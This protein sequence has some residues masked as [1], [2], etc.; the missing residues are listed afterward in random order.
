MSGKYNFQEGD[1]VALLNDNLEGKVVR[2]LPGNKI[3]VQTADGFEMPLNPAEL[4]LVKSHSTETRTGAPAAE[5]AD[6]GTP[7]SVAQARESALRPSIVITKEVQKADMTAFSLYLVNPA[8]D[9]VLYCLHRCVPAGYELIG[10]GSLMGKSKLLLAGWYSEQMEEYRRWYAGVFPLEQHTAQ[11][12]AWLYLPLQL[13]A[14]SL[15]KMKNEEPLTGK[16]GVAFLFHAETEA[17]P[18]PASIVSQDKLALKTEKSE[19]LDEVIDLHTEALGINP[20][21]LSAESII[22]KQMQV[23][24]QTLNAARERRLGH[25]VFIHGVGSGRLKSRI[26]TYLA[27]AAAGVDR[28]E[29]AAISKYGY[30][31]TIVYLSLF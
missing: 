15:M 10:G 27:Q 23:F 25:I 12:P 6:A 18:T 22:Q 3:L 1:T 20:R 30:G 9:P 11:K 19:K 2:L 5:R 14:A 4:V 21:G 24:E 7:I 13:N 16:T 26:W 17:L 29:E 28:F 31:A 8:T